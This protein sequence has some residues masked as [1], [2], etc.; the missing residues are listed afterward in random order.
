MSTGMTGPAGPHHDRGL[1]LYAEGDPAI[2]LAPGN[3]A[4]RSNLAATRIALGDYAGA[5]E[6]CNHAIR[7]NSAHLGGFNNRAVARTELGDAAGA[8]VDAAEAI[9]LDPRC[10]DA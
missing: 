7:I 2:Q 8:L 1:A 4:E 3:A 5:L 9:R 10:A 6:D